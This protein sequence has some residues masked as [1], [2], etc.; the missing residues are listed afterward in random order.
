M[1]PIHVFFLQSSLRIG[2]PS[3]CTHGAAAAHAADTCHSVA[4][5]ATW[6]APKQLDLL[7]H[8][9]FWHRVA[10][11]LPPLQRPLSAQQLWRPQM[12][13][14]HRNHQVGHLGPRH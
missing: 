7:E 14:G 5:A 8:N 10:G 2:G 1:G 13:R 9:S 11:D 6:T 4:D 12:C 3:A